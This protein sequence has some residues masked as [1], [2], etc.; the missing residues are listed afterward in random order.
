MVLGPLN[1][2]LVS[3]VTAGLGTSLTPALGHPIA[4]GTKLEHLITALGFLPVP[5]YFVPPSASL[6]TENHIVPLFAYQLWSQYLLKNH[7][8]AFWLCLVFVVFMSAFSS[9]G[10]QELLLI[11]VHRLLITVD[12]LLWSTGC[13]CKSFSRHGLCALELVGFSNCSPRAPGL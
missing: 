3:E 4:L 1:F 9:Y 12:S 10:E 7:L 5:P 11:V 6:I 13:R 8:F 2:H